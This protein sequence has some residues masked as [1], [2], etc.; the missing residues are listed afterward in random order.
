MTGLKV[1]KTQ[2]YPNGKYLQA[3]GSTSHIIAE[4]C[5]INVILTYP[6]RQ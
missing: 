3:N 5:P 6:L 1:E 4:D 2:K